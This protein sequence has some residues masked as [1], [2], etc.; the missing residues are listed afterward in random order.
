MMMRAGTPLSQMNVFCVTED[1]RRHA[2]LQMKRTHHTIS[3][4]KG[5]YERISRVAGRTKYA[6]PSTTST[7]SYPY[8]HIFHH[9]VIKIQQLFL[10]TAACLTSTL[11][12]TEVSANDCKCSQNQQ[13]NVPAEARSSSR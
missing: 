8:I 2:A 4:N 1:K 11:L 9:V 13:L 6:L 10:R 7:S 3:L 5:G 12:E